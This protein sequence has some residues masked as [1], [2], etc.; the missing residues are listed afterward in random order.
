MANLQ[1]AGILAKVAANPL[2]KLAQPIGKGQ[3]AKAITGIRAR[4]S[5][6]AAIASLIPDDELAD[7]NI[8]PG[9]F[10]KNVCSAVAV[11]VANAAA[12]SGGL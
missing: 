7:Q 9:I 10:N 2:I 3:G 4:L 11:A 8:I 6:A 12:F 1:V 5:A